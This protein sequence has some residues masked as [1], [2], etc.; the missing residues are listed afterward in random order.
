MVVSSSRGSSRHFQSAR[1]S[2]TTPRK[3][4]YRLYF[5]VTQLIERSILLNIGKRNDMII[6]GRQPKIEKKKLEGVTKTRKIK[7]WKHAFKLAIPVF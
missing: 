2:K 5:T 1:K 6:S 7:I 3:F 4:L